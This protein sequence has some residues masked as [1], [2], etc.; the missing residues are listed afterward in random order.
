MIH[1]V[2]IK[3]KPN[4]E[5]YYSFLDLPDTWYYQQHDA[6]FNSSLSKYGINYIKA[7]IRGKDGY[8]AGYFEAKV[9]LARLS[10]AEGHLAIFSHNMIKMASERFDSLMD[11]LSTEEVY[12][13][14]YDW[15]LARIDYCYDIKTPH[16]QTY[17]NLLKKG[18]KPYFLHLPMDRYGRPIHYK[19]S[20]YLLGSGYNVNFY[21]K[22]R[23]LKDTE[24]IED[25]DDIEDDILRLEIQC[26]Y[27]KVTY[28]KKAFD[29]SVRNLPYYLTEDLSIYVV[30]KTLK[31]ITRSETLEYIRKNKAFERIDQS[32]HTKKIKSELKQIISDI[33]KQHSSIW[34]VRERYEDEGIMKRQTYNNRLKMLNNLNINPVVL[35]DNAR[36]QGLKPKDGLITLYGLFC[37]LICTFDFTGEEYF[38]YLDEME[39][40]EIGELGELL[41]EPI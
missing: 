3:Y 31:D 11:S 34:K 25:N 33:S 39:N 14:F 8:V 9:N 4:S 15:S 32:R 36:I 37:G 29:I 10:G 41:S 2:L 26:H 19:T 24:R 16:T 23:Q 18:D 17:I 6:Y 27:T 30:K 40:L 1:T 12:P 38:N 21:D 22:K 13:S 20:L 28:L 7:C 35:S 5:L